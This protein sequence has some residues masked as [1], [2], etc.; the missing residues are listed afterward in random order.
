MFLG[1]AQQDKYVLNVLSQKK[2]GYLIW[3]VNLE[4][5]VCVSNVK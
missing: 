5:L 1:Q 3:L 2:D 4:R